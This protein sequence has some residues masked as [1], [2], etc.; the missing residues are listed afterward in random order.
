MDL[1]SVTIQRFVDDHFPGFVEC[2]FT[3]SDG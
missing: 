2:I 3:D 1:I